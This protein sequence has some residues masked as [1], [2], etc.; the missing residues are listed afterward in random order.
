MFSE[1]RAPEMPD[2]PTAKEIGVNTVFEE[3][4][5]AF[6]PKGTPTVNVEVLGKALEA[7]TKDPEIIKHLKALGVDGVYIDGPKLTAMLSDLKGPIRK[8]GDAV[9]K[10]RAEEGKK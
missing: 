4:V 6:T 2:V 8:V 7:A 1:E 9:K 3:R 10:T 5:I